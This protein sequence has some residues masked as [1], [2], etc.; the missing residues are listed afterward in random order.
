MSLILILMMN[1]YP[2]PK[3][4]TND[5]FLRCTPPCTMEDLSPLL[6]DKLDI[7][8]S[9]CGFPLIVNSAYRTFDYEQ[10]KG[11]TGSSSHCKHIAVDIAVQSGEKR[12]KIVQNALRA[13]FQRIGIA[14]TFVHLDL[15]ADKPSAIW[16]Y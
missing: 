9:L 12:L 5:E 6:L 13:G 14:R 15:D 4:F 7:V 11:R 2:N 16:L 3:Y 8:R 1:K 10:D